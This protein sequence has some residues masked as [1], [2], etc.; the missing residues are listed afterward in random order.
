LRYLERGDAVLNA[1]QTRQLLTGLVPHFANGTLWDTIKDTASGAAN[2][3]AGKVGDVGSWLGD[4]YEAIEKFV[5]DPI[6]QI[7]AVFD[8]YAG[9]ISG[10]FGNSFGVNG[11]HYLVKSGENWFKS[12]FDKLNTNLADPAGSGVERWRSYVEKALNMLGLSSSLVNKVLKQINT[13]S[14]GNAK[15]QGGDDGLSDGK[16]MGLMQVKPGT[17]SAN[18]VKGHDNIWNGFDNMLAGLNYAQK[19]YG[20][21][22]SFLGQGHG[23]ANGGLI[24][25]HRMIEVG[26][27]NNPE[28]VV[29]LDKM[30]SSRAWQLM[31]QVVSHFSGDETDANL[32][33]DNVKDSEELKNLSAKLDSL[34]TLFSQMLQLTAAQTKTIRDTAFSKDQLYKQ[35]ALD[36]IMRDAQTI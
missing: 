18:K 7:T 31:A 22:L 33:Q 26:E 11:G 15:A 27:G 21:D 25:S 6:G 23:Y 34:I 30:K 20:A 2:Y 35:Q 10:R 14:G 32:S 3:V 24:N 1:T 16:A 12:L 5:K 36:Q 19:R 13:E 29:P 8:K 28:M 9:S 4:K 17:F